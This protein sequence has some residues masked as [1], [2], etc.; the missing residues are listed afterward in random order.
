MNILTRLRRSLFVKK[1]LVALA[2][3]AIGFLAF[4]YLKNQGL[5]NPEKIFDIL[6]AYPRQAPIAFIALYVLLSVVLVPTLPLNMGA[7]FL[8]GPVIGTTLSIIGATAGAVVA[9]LVARYLVGDFFR[10]RFEHPAWLWLHQQIEDNPWQSVAFTRINPIFS[11]GPLNYFYG[12][13]AVS[14]P[15]YTWSTALFLIPPSALFATLGSSL[16]DFTLTGAIASLWRNILILSAIF[17][18]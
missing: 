12:I 6:A 2:G 14:L 11:F 15:T 3:L 18:V 4:G 10:R 16:N 9:F 1:Q 5:I 7:G 17:T 13:T 8:W